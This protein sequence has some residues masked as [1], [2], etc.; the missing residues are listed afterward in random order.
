MPQAKFKAILA[1]NDA[2]PEACLLL[3][4]SWYQQVRARLLFL[5]GLSIGGEEEEP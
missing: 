3:V 5:T 2:F 4:S 1:Y